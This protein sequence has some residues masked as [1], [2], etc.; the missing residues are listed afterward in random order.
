MHGFTPFIMFYATRW[1]VSAVIANG[2]THEVLSIRLAQEN[3]EMYPESH[4]GKLGK[5]EI[6]GSVLQWTFVELTKN[7]TLH[8]DCW[9]TTD[10]LARAGYNLTWPAWASVQ[11]QRHLLFINP[12]ALSSTA[13]INKNFNVCYVTFRSSCITCFGGNEIKVAKR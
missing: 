5:N 6:S 2:S 4:S 10:G 11:S 9:R 12:V 8:F 7:T 1:S 3:R 13:T